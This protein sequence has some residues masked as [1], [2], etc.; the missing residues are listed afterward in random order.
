MVKLWR[1]TLFDWK[2]FSH[3]M[4]FHNVADC[5]DRF[6]HTHQ[7]A[8]K[9]SPEQKILVTIPLLKLKTGSGTKEDGNTRFFKNLNSKTK[10]NF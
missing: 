4:R 5:T 1:C 10:D 6:E 2:E 9:R 3:N 8:P 7:V